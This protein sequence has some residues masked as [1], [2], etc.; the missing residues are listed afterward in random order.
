MTNAGATTLTIWRFSSSLL[1]LLLLVWSGS[2]E[3]SPGNGTVTNKAVGPISQDVRVE[4]PDGIDIVWV[5]DLSATPP[6]HIKTYYA[7]CTVS[8]LHRIHVAPPIKVVYQDC[9]EDANGPAVETWGVTAFFTEWT[10]AVRLSQSTMADIDLTDPHRGS[11]GDAVSRFGNGNSATP[12]LSSDGRIMV[13]ASDASDLVRRDTTGVSDIFHFDQLT[14]QL[15]RITQPG[16]IGSE[17]NGSSFAPDVD[18]AGRLVVFESNATNLVPDT[19]GAKDIF[20]RDV[21][22]A[23]YTRVSVDSIGTQ[24]NGLSRAATISGDGSTI[25]FA[26]NATNLVPSDTN[27]QRDVF[28]YDVITGAV[29]RV[30]VATGGVQATGGFGGSDDP[31]ISSDGRYVAFTSNATNLVASDGNGSPD[32]FVHDRQTGNTERVSLSET[33]TEVDGFSSLPSISANGRYVA[34][35]NDSSDIVAGF[36]GGSP[37]IFLRDRTGATTTW[38]SDNGNSDHLSPQI[39]DDGRFVIY[40]SESSDIVV[41]DTNGALRDAIL[42]DRSSGTNVIVS[43]NSGGLQTAADSGGFSNGVAISGDGAVVAFE[44]A[45]TDL[46]PGDANSSEDI[47]LRDLGLGET[48]LGSTSHYGT[49]PDAGINFVALSGDGE[50]LAFA[51]S[52][53]NLVAGDTLGHRDIYVAGTLGRVR[54]VVSVG[55]GGVLGNGPSGSPTLSGDGSLVA[56]DSFADNLVASDLNLTSDVFVH[57]VAT[58]STTRISVTSGGIEANDMSFSPSIS[59][60]GRYVAFISYGSNLEPGDINISRDVFLHDRQTGMTEAVSKTDGG[61]GLGDTDSGDDRFLGDGRYVSDDGRYIAFGSDA[62]N[63]SAA[64]TNI[65]RDI[66]VRDRTNS[67][68]ILVSQTAGGLSGNL[69]SD[70]PAMSRD[71]R[72]VVFV[73]DASDLVVGDSNA[74]RD[75]FL[76]DLLD[77][78]NPVI[79]RISVDSGGVQANG[80]SGANGGLSLSDDGRFVYFS[81]QATN[82]IASDTNGVTADI[83]VRDRMLSQTLLRSQGL[84]GVQGDAASDGT[85]TTSSGLLYAYESLATNLLP[86]DSNGIRDVMLSGDDTDGDGA[87]DQFDAFPNDETENLDN[88]GDGIGDNLDLDDDNDGVSDTDEFIHNMS[89]FSPADAAEDF[90]GDGFTNAE[91]IAAGS[92]PNDNMSLPPAVPALGPYGTAFLV[93]LLASLAIVSFMGRVSRRA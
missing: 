39:S 75:V 69:D 53:S 82:L 48:R 56:Y 30:S 41:P 12:N 67:K 27:A 28:A 62:T 16:T 87:L 6:A 26:S 22:S 74:A 85:S 93:I 86:D 65:Y 54:G 40:S 76:A 45:G 15:V 51:S 3:A 34:F 58:G 13:F 17:A 19:N 4:D 88:D 91:E 31:A 35:E 8:S 73:S 50:I 37:H 61:S 79:E 60:N 2:A 20:V 66:F 44:S 5:M 80:A 52:A 59:T 38:V 43:K 78:D 72:Y 92:D 18:D 57:E 70:R 9:Q 47:F 10:E 55:P 14:G 46:V 89:P 21:E 90:D 11:L 64:D 42:W 24:A 81:S 36:A 77:P 29:T 33:G 1:F 68:T 7:G 84:S 83:Y 23:L 49:Q 32:I 25:V 63:L 71:G